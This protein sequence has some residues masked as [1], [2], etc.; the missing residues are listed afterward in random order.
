MTLSPTLPFF[1][2]FLTKTEEVSSQGGSEYLLSEDVQTDSE[3]PCGRIGIKE[4]AS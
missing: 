3:R 2:T 1:N 4:T